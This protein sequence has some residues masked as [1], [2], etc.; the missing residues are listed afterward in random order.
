MHI[1]YNKYSLNIHDIIYTLYTHIIQIFNDGDDV[2]TLKFINRIFTTQLK[3]IKTLL[4]HL[5]N[6][7]SSNIIFYL[8]Q[9]S[10]SWGTVA[11]DCSS[12]TK[13]CK[14]SIRETNNADGKVDLIKKLVSHHNHDSERWAVHPA[15]R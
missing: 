13:T 7:S 6:V 11:I 15:V 2:F 4:I 12:A 1:T 5:H 10:F 9:K 14:L 8:L 3:F